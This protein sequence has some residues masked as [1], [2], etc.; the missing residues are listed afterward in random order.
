MHASN[1]REI[2]IVGVAIVVIAFVANLAGVFD[3]GD[4]G[5]LTVEGV[6]PSASA[7]AT[8]RTS[9]AATGSPSPQTTARSPAGSSAPADGE[10]S[11][12]SVTSPV[13]LGAT[14]S[15]TA[16]ANPGA[17]CTI[18]Y[19]HPSGKTSVATGLEPKPAGSDG[20]VTWSWGISTNTKP[21]GNGS[22]TVTC[23]GKSAET[24]IVIQ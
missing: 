2:A 24:P 14:A 20:T 17:N 8:P 22:V 7:S 13:G 12:V 6:A 3:T 1:I 4:N 5:A 21:V 16:R 23:D 15:L 9:G 19:T 11:I 18:V 10:V